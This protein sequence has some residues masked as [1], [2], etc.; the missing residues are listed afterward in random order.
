MREYGSA[1][2]LRA[3]ENKLVL[4]IGKGLAMETDGRWV[5]ATECRYIR[6]KILKGGGSARPGLAMPEDGGLSIYEP[7]SAFAPTR[8]EASGYT[9]MYVCDGL[10][11][12]NKITV[13][14]DGEL[15]IRQ[16][17]WGHSPLLPVTR[18]TFSADLS[19][20]AGYLFTE[21]IFCRRD[22]AGRVPAFESVPA[23]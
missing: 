16:P 7:V 12:V 11:T 9:G 13:A 2:T 8:N 14:D 20:Q 19:A 17:K 5:R 4:V 22:E 6:I 15:E 21:T 18:D 1:W 3:G 10:G 23:G